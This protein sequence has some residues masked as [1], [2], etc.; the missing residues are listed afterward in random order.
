MVDLLP[1]TRFSFFL[2]FP[3]FVPYFSSKVQVADAEILLLDVIVQSPLATWDLFCMFREDMADRLSSFDQR[4]DQFIQ[5]DQFVLRQVD[6]FSGLME[7]FPVLPIRI[8]CI[9]QVL[10]KETAARLTACIADIRR[11]LFDLTGIV[12]KVRTPLITCITLPA[13]DL[14]LAVAFLSADV[15]LSATVPILAAILVESLTD[16][17]GLVVTMPADLL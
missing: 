1:R 2:P 13:W 16:L 6:P 17:H 3:L 7:F 8:V 12:H 14:A 11:F 4:T 5:F 10:V 9:I 15:P